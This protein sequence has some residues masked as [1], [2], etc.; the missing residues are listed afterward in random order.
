MTRAAWWRLRERML[1][2]G[3]RQERTGS[4]G[5]EPAEEARGSDRAED[6]VHTHPASISPES[7]ER[8]VGC[9]AVL[10]LLLLVSGVTVVLALANGYWDVSWE[11]VI[12][13]VASVLFA[14]CVAALAWRVGKAWQRRRN[15]PTEATPPAERAKDDQDSVGKP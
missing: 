10:G 6:P 4:A 11:T 8:I 3:E 1:V 14:T 13:A 15:G 12:W 9:V 5:E 2:S 7:E